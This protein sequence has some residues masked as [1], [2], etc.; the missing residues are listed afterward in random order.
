MESFGQLLHGFAVALTWKNLLYCLM[1]CVWGTA[2]GMLPGLG[3][4]AGMALLLPLTFGLDP[5][6]AVIM[7]AGIFYGAMYGGSTT[8]ILARIPGEAASVVTCIDGHE[9][10]KKGRAGPALVVAAVGS[11]VGGTLSVVGLTL[12]APM[13]ADAM[14]RVGPAA[15]FILMVLAL[16]VV[17]FVSSGPMVKTLAMLLLGLAIAT[18]GLDPLTAWPRFTYGAITLSDGIAFVPLSIGLFGVS[19][20]LLDLDRRG[21]MRPIKP[22]LRDLMPNARDLR[23]SA[24]AI[25][26]GSVIGFLFG[27]IPGISHV[28]S[29]FVS[30]AV[31]KRLSKTPQEFG[32][33]AIAGVAGP[34]AANNATTGSSMIPLLVLG[35]PAIPV[36]AILLSAMLIHGVRP[37]PQLISD[38]PNVFW[39]LIASMYVGNLLLLLLNLPLVGVFVS[40]LRIPRAYL[41][42]SI[43]L[44]CLVGVYSVNA[45]VVDIWIMVGSGIVGYLFRKFGFDVAP[46][47]LALVLGDRIEISFRRALSISGGDYAVFYQGAA[48]KVFLSALSVLLFV[49]CASWAIGYRK[50]SGNRDTSI[51]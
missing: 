42:P 4:L 28:I 8:S 13:L 10:A 3:P 20:I 39:G 12:F 2:V 23:Q 14:L 50:R 29:T 6:T 1:G 44:I 35:I 17:A 43:L 26:R 38:H 32:Q 48:A 40:L 51:G 37:G 15:E 7:L 36:T 9:M 22:R 27:V 33:G 45:N 25:G 11:F 18:I 30:Y 47:L 21:A 31:E 24:P 5:A 34:E 41:T 49:Q 16:L 46:L 19:E